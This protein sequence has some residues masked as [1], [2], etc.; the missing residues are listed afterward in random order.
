M[1]GEELK[2]ADFIACY[3]DSGERFAVEAF[4]PSDNMA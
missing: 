3:N 2:V 4:H 1:N